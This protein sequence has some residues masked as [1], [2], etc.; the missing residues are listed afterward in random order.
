MIKGKNF[1][2]SIVLLSILIPLTASVQAGELLLTIEFED[3][4]I[5]RATIEGF[6]LGL[7][8]DEPKTALLLPAV[9][10]ARE[11]A[12]RM[13]DAVTK[14]EKIPTIILQTTAENTLYQW[15][16]QN[17]MVKSYSMHGSSSAGNS[18]PVESFSLNYEK[19]EV[20]YNG[21]SKHYDCS[22][23]TC[24]LEKDTSGRTIY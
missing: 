13:E 14:N 18:V 6:K 11:A 16:L 2:F 10:A 24:I 9:Q 12:R 20:S 23:R 19:V 5:Q 3:G 1:F 7:E 17:A 4:S 8:G 15:R 21:E 22:S